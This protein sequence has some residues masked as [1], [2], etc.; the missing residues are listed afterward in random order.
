[1][2]EWQSSR[3]NY[4][5]KTAGDLERE[6]IKLDHQTILLQTKQRQLIKPHPKEVE[7]FIMN[8]L[9]VKYQE[10]EANKE[11]QRTKRKRTED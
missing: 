8:S 10:A 7:Q 5:S 11:K 4:E 2:D 9:E 1:M 6:R 3:L